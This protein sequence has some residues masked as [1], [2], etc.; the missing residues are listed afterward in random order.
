MKNHFTIRVYGIYTSTNNKVL[1]S[2]EK[3]DGIWYHKF[4]GGGMEFGE[5]TV[6]CLKREFQEEMNLTIQVKSHFYTTDFFVQSKFRAQ[7]QVLAIYYLIDGINQLPEATNPEIQG[8]SFL[9]ICSENTDFLSFETDQ[10]AFK[11]LIKK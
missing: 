10:K 7:C 8:F 9:N 2:S 4:P 6:D 1:I 3:I 5:G 11:L